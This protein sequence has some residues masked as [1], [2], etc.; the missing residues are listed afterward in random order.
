MTIP[1]ENFTEPTTGLCPE[2]LRVVDARIFAESGRVWIEQTCPEH[3]SS[4][5]LHVGEYQRDVTSMSSN[6]QSIGPKMITRYIWGDRLLGAAA[7]VA[8]FTLLFFVFSGL[9]ILAPILASKYKYIKEGTIVG[10][11]FS[12]VTFLLIYMTLAYNWETRN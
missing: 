2:C 9:L 8:G 6:P 11:V 3:G 12:V 1:A 4:R 10:T 7:G 5:A